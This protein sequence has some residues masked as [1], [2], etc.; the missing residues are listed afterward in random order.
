MTTTDQ[1]KALVRSHA[2]GNDDQFYAVAL[3]VAARAARQ[4]NTKMAA[5]LREAVDAAKADP[6][7]PK[8]RSLRPVPVVQPRGELSGLL[9]VSYPRLHL[10]DLV[11][12]KSVNTRLKRVLTEQRRRND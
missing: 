1:L 10:T 8:E 7:R 9:A 5:E 12:E 3:Q 6:N 2:E 11:V 4:G